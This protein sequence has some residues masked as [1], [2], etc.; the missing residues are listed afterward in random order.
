ML[1]SVQSSPLL[2]PLDSLAAKTATSDSFSL[3]LQQLIANS[4]QQLGLQGSSVQVVGAG[5]SSSSGRQFCVTIGDTPKVAADTQPAAAVAPAPE[6]D[7]D[8]D[9][10][11]ITPPYSPTMFATSVAQA[12]APVGL[13]AYGGETY[14]P[15]RL[16]R[17]TAMAQVCGYQEA[18]NKGYYDWVQ[19]IVG[20]LKAAGHDVELSWDTSDD[21]GYADVPHLASIKIKDINPDWTLSPGLGQYDTWTWGG[22]DPIQRLVHCAENSVVA[23]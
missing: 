16:T 22:L 14:V 3:Q 8:I 9:P 15:A 10:T 21:S 12:T 19:S 20:G 17:F 23:V 18:R 1:S 13:T 6:P 4:M 11:Q 2:Q 7:P 5:D